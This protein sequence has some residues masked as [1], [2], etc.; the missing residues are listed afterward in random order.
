M[1][2]SQGV[3]QS[4][5][6]LQ[7]ENTCLILEYLK[8]LLLVRTGFLI[9]IDAGFPVL[10]AGGV[11]ELAWEVEGTKLYEKGDTDIY[12]LLSKVVQTYCS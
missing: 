6:L 2:F 4:L 5:P 11:L 12:T 10:G 9:G 3:E 7:L 8:S 1:F